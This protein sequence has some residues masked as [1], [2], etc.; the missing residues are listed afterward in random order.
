MKTYTVT[1]SCWWSSSDTETTPFYRV[2]RD[3][4]TEVVGGGVPLTLV[5]VYSAVVEDLPDVQMVFK[6][7]LEE[8]Q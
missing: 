3:D 7:E 2:F 8:R 4:G 6:F 1:M 5:E